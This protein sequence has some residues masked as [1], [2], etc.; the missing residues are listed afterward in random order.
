LGNCF[1]LS[2]KLLFG[3]AFSLLVPALVWGRAR[4]LLLW[5]LLLVTGWTNIT[6]HTA[7]LSPNDLRN[8]FSQEPQLVTI[9]GTLP[10]TPTLRVFEVDEQESWRTMA[11][12][13]VTEV[14]PHR[15]AWRPAAG[16]IAVT[17]PGTLTNLFASQTVEVTGV[18]AP[19]KTATAEGTFDYRFYLK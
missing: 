18:V 9:R 13:D 14:R 16:R 4:P 5:P 12:V 19:P 6:L 10:E 11:R 1:S 17:T 8:I 2:T 15:Q 3:T 7:V